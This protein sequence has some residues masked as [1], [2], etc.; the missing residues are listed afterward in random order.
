[1]KIRVDINKYFPVISAVFRGWLRSLRYTPIGARDKQAFELSRAGKPLIV[2]VWHEELVA[3]AGLQFYYKD[4]DFAVMVS[5]SKDGELIA[6]AVEECGISTVRGS[7]S[8]G[9]V[10]ALLGLK[11]KIEKENKVGVIALDGPRG[12]RHDVKDGIIYLAHKMNAYI[13]PLRVNTGAKVTCNSWDRFQI[14]MPF[15]KSRIY[16][17]MP[18]TLPKGDLDDAYME[19]EKRNLKKKLEDLGP[20]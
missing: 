15:S 8:R 7:S 20:I 9:G 17:G 12:P 6:R 5:Q 10:R 3:L 11:R 4:I 19:K 2:A 18:Y 13:V 1:M 14:P 16:A